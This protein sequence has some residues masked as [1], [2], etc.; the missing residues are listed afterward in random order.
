MF[1]TL[2]LWRTC[3]DIV[4]KTASCNQSLTQFEKFICL[5][6]VC[7]R[8]SLF[9]SRRR[10]FS[11][12][13]MSEDGGT[14]EPAIV[15]EGKARIVFPNPNEVFYNPAQVINRD[16][17]LAVTGLFAEDFLKPKGVTVSYNFIENGQSEGSKAEGTSSQSEDSRTAHNAE[18]GVQSQ[19]TEEIK[20]CHPGQKC[21]EGL[22]F[23]EALSASGLRSVRIAKE[24]PGI[25]RVVANDFSEEA[26]RDIERNIKFNNVENLVEPSHCDASLL[27]YQHRFKDSF[28]V[29]DLDPYGSAA[30]FL[31]SGVQAVRNGGL[32]C[33]TCTDMAVLCGNHGHACFAKYGAMALRTKS[34]L[35]MALRIVLNC[36]ETQANRYNRYIV[37]VLSVAVD[38][39]V[40]VFVRVHIS[41]SKVKYAPSKKAL[42]Y[43]CSGCGSISLQRLGKVTFKDNNPNPVFQPATGPPVGKSCEHCGSSFHVG[44]PIWADPIH[45]IDFVK[46]LIKHIDTHPERFKYKDRMKGLMT[47]VSEEL[48]DCPLYYITSSLCHVLHCECPSQEKVRS[49]ILNA[50]YRVS[51]S[52]ASAEAIKTDAP[53]GVI[54]DILR[55]WVKDHPVSQKRLTPGSPATSILS[56]EPSIDVNFQSHPE[57]IPKS[58]NMIRFPENPE[59]NWGPRA[60]AKM[61]A[62]NETLEEKRKRLQ[63]KNSKRKLQNS[64]ESGQKFARNDHEDTAEDEASKDQSPR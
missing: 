54:W 3:G 57:A 41:Q 40:R 20:V 16:L 46:R 49:A 24:V 1:S 37:P 53:A 19:R 59:A 4:V 12:T 55:A 52:H 10:C 44:G 39:Y 61:M 63:G 50:G 9:H 58:R 11:Q 27:M 22:T 34:C 14:E 25:K 32:L 47:V 17:S 21:E 56:K 29:V 35:E 15:E 48:S 60:R 26:V 8:R 2:H 28:N 42:I 30:Q 7:P 5:S 38:F 23:L 36:I 45:D 62:G 64:D 13:S 6:E 51:I 43:Q 31:D 33:V 18:E